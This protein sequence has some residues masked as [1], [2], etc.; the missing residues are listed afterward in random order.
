MILFDVLS[1]KLFDSQ[2]AINDMNNHDEYDDGFGQELPEVSLV[3]VAAG[4]STRMGAHKNKPW[5]SLGGKAVVFRTLEAFEGMKEIS[6]IIL[7][8]SKEDEEYARKI[9][10]SELKDRGVSMITTGGESRYDSS[11]NGISL[12]NSM[13]D[14]IAIHDAVRPFLKQDTL[15]A[16]FKMARDYGAA[17]PAIPVQD[18]LKR[19][20]G[21]KIIGS[22]SR[23][24]AMAVQT[25][26]CFRRDVIIDAFE[27]ARS[28]GGVS[29][30]I[31]DEAG[32]VEYFGREISVILGSVYNMK[33]TTKEDLVLADALIKSGLL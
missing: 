31:T 16:L 22:I 19:V 33:L 6:E 2:E 24:G 23:I 28:T 4:A 7:V 3:I 13:S 21:D 8:V 11:W 30:N 18:S 1:I 20:E 32:L 26:Q 9:V 25:P 10:G 12:T 27:Y 5:L 14:V 29:D 17:V 15:K